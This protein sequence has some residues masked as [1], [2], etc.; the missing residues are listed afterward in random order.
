MNQP[1]PARRYL[2]IDR[3][4][5]S[6]ET[7]SAEDV[8]RALAG[9][10]SDPSLAMEEINAGQTISTPGALYCLDRIK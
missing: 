6:V 9:H 3:A 4:G 5:G 7:V 10:Y 1:E 2:R 8:R